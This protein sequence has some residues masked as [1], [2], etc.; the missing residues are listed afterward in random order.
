MG[1]SRAVAASWWHWVYYIPT[2]ECIIYWSVWVGET[3]TTGTTPPTTLG[4]IPIKEASHPTREASILEAI[5]QLT[6]RIPTT[7]WEWTPT[8]WIHTIIRILTTQVRMAWIRTLWVWTSNLMEWIRTR[9]IWGWT[10]ITQASII[11][12]MGWLIQATV[13]KIHTI[14]LLP[15]SSS[16]QVAGAAMVLE[17]LW[18]EGILTPAEDALRRLATAEGAMALVKTTS[19]VKCAFTAMTVVTADVTAIAEVITVAT[20]ITTD[21]IAAATAIA[22]GDSW[23]YAVNCSLL[24]EQNGKV[25]KK[26]RNEES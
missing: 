17:W 1:K 13:G 26:N 20:A 5:T 18:D 15:P 14:L 21:I 22:T 2:T 24:L 25:A 3:T 12:V 6:Q 9:W 8:Q 4:S 11:T 10:P 16:N 19:P 7:T 23:F